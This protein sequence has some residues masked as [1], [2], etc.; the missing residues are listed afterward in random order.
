MSKHYNNLASSSLVLRRPRIT[1]K[2]ASTAQADKSVYTFEVAAGANKSQVKSAVRELFKV[3]P[4]RINMINT[5]EKNIFSRRKRG[6]V[7]GIKKA[8]IYLKK[9]DKI[10]V[11]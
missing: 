2:A 3:T 11:I 8:M 10:D 6:V 4:V 9:G 1:E 5:P 7:S